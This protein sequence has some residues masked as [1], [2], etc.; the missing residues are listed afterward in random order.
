MTRSKAKAAPKLCILDFVDKIDAQVRVVKALN[1]LSTVE[2]DCTALCR[3]YAAM[4]D[5]HL[6]AM[7]D[8]QRMAYNLDGVAPKPHITT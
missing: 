2:G 3:V 6:D 8:V 5:N 4:I 1:G 7:L